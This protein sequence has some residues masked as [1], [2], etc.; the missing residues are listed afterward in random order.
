MST[1]HINI[2]ASLYG[3]LASCVTSQ[4]KNWSCVYFYSWSVEIYNLLL[5]NRYYWFI[6]L[7]L[8]FRNLVSFPYKYQRHCT[9]FHIRNSFMVIATCFPGAFRTPNVGSYLFVFSVPISLWTH[10]LQKNCVW[11]FAVTQY[12]VLIYLVQLLKL[13]R[14]L[15]SCIRIYIYIHI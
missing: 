13:S 9:F 5:I 15:F 1:N 7:Q 2:Q 14:C 11:L 8:T 4:I 10:L 6:I 3:K 12:F